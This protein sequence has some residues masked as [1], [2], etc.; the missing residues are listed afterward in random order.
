[1]RTEFVSEV[2]WLRYHKPPI[3]MPVIPIT[4]TNIHQNI[5]F[6]F[7]ENIMISCERE[8]EIFFLR[9]TENEP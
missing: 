1:M 4:T 6:S 3:E 8:D 5:D 7:I 2:S 9:F